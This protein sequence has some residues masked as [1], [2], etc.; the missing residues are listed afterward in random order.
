MGGGVGGAF[1]R[2]GVIVVGGAVVVVVV[3]VVDQRG[4]FRV[5]VGEV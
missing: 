4:G 1:G 2:H 5:G 3:V